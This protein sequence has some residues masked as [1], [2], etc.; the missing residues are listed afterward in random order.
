MPNRDNDLIYMVLTE[1]NRAG[2]TDWAWR[3]WGLSIAGLSSVSGALAL[4]IFLSRHMQAT[5]TMTA[6]IAPVMQTARQHV[7]TAA[8][9]T[10]LS[11]QPLAPAPTLTHVI[12]DGQTVYT[13]PPLD[14]DP[15][16]EL[17]DMPKA[18]ANLARPPY[19]V[20]AANLETR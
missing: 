14:P 12:A 3:G 13:G 11:L 7:R 15:D 1:L 17:A 20:T 19:G 18:P 10:A 6:P 9:T 2:K 16:G 8:F 5:E 4:I